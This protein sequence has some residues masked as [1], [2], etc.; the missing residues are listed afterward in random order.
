MKR[1]LSRGAA[2]SGRTDDNLE[3]LEKRFNTYFNET[4][5]IIKYYEGKNLLR[6]IDA[7]KSPDEVFEDVKDL[8]KNLKD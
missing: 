3:S 1:C 2:G 7:T 4:Q 8:F 5:P 6:S